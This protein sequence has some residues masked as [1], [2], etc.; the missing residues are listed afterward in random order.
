MAF[1]QLRG[2]PI[3]PQLSQ[4]CGNAAIASVGF[5]VD[6]DDENRPPRDRRL[7]DMDRHR[8]AAGNDRQRFALSRRRLRSPFSWRDGGA[9]AAGRRPA[10]MKSTM[11]ITAGTSAKCA[12]TRV[13]ALGARPRRAKIS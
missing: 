1:E 2:L 3:W 6:A 5:A 13:D 9:R 10:R 12:A 11:I 8:P 4:T 7:G